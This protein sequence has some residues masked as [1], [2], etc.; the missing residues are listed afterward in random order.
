[1]FLP[2]DFQRGSSCIY[3]LGISLVIRYIILL[4]KRSSCANTRTRPWNFEVDEEASSVCHRSKQC[5]YEPRVRLQSWSG[6]AGIKDDCCASFFSPVSYFPTR[7]K[8]Y[9]HFRHV[10][11]P[12]CSVSKV[13][14][15]LFMGTI[16]VLQIYGYPWME[17]VS[18]CCVPFPV[19]FGKGRGPS[20]IATFRLRFGQQVQRFC[21]HVDRTGSS[22][23]GRGS[24]WRYD[25]QTLNRSVPQ[26]IHRL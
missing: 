9:H 26:R 11:C 7:I 6:Q 1:M 17:F 20:V 13:E 14:Y 5:D 18:S 8:R 25:S 24:P 21:N 16:S 23:S 4:G 10:F 15:N 2:A 3:N 22:S 12:P 19:P